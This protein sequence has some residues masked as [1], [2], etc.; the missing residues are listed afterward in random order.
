[1]VI[2]IMT[3]QNLIVSTLIKENDESIEQIWEK[4]YVKVVSCI[5]EL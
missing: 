4:Q 1:M 3:N 5:R 2:G